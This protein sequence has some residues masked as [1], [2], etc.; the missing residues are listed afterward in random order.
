[1]CY[2]A[3]S[4]TFRSVWSKASGATL[5]IASLARGSKSSTAACLTLTP[6]RI[7]AA[8]LHRN[9]HTVER[10]HIRRG[11]VVDFV[12]RRI[13]NHVAETTDHDLFEPRVD[14]VLVP[15]EP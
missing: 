4:P 12:L 3:P 5:R 2:R 11:P 6:S 14:Q 13:S 7:N 10:Q 15:E 9:R 1:M 8:K